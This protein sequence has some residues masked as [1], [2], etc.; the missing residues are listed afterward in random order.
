MVVLD[1][2]VVHFSGWAVAM[3][4]SKPSLNRGDPHGQAAT[5]STF[6]LILYC[7]TLLLS[8]ISYFV[9]SYVVA[10]TLWCR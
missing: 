10:I 8:S 3:R 6:L 4:P 1:V 9:E 7:A 5:A 2:Y